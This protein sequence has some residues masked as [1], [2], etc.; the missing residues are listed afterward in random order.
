MYT[1]QVNIKVTPYIK[2]PI[3]TLCIKIKPVPNGLATFSIKL[4]HILVC[5]WIGKA[6]IEFWDYDQRV[7]SQKYCFKSKNSCWNFKSQQ[8][9]FV[10]AMQTKLSL[11]CNAELKFAYVT[12]KLDTIR[13]FPAQ[14]L[15]CPLNFVMAKSKTQFCLRLFI[16]G[17]E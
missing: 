12:K 4:Q 13:D 11:R 7:I 2:M 3:K 17:P 8:M 9:A 6:N 16:S 10:F 5:N 1:L 14:N 15:L